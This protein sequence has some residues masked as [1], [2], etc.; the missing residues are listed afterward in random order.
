[1]T[2]NKAITEIYTFSKKIFFKDYSIRILQHILFNPKLQNL[3]KKIKFEKKLSL[4]KETIAKLNE[5]QMRQI[6]GGLVDEDG[7]IVYDP[8]VTLARGGFSLWRCVK[9]KGT[10]LG[11]TCVTAGVTCGQECGPISLHSECSC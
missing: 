2:D 3:M 5:G 8:H 11:V 7:V 9:A 6:Q 10:A 1:M 4:N